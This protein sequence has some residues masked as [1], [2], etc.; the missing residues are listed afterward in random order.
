MRFVI[1]AAWLLLAFSSVALAGVI[2]LPCE[3]GHVST[4]GFEPCTACGP[5][6]FNPDFGAI[7]CQTCPTGTFAS[8]P[9]A[10]SCAEPVTIYF[11]GVVGFLKPD[12][13]GP[14]PFEIGTTFEGYCIL[15]PTVPDTNPDPVT[16]AFDGAMLE[17]AVRA[18]PIGSP[19]TGFA[20][21]GNAT[22]FQGPSISDQ[23]YLV[24]DGFSGV[25]APSPE[26][27]QIQLVRNDG[28]LLDSDALAPALAVVGAY[29]SRVLTWFYGSGWASAGGADLSVPEPGA[30]S[31]AL[32]GIAALITLYARRRSL[33]RA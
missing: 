21:G 16:G 26:S 14:D 17:L 32:A 25:S 7:A 27:F 10:A 31:V 18:G 15:N 13:N 24:P 29:D 6:S 20:T 9:G 33:L 19:L 4:N 30:G 3:P 1:T 28:T 8:T 12:P 23:L 22:V 11:E 2:G 5:G